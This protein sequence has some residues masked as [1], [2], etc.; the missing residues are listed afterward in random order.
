M[1]TPMH[2]MIRIPEH[3]MEVAYNEHNYPGSAFTDLSEGANC[4][5]FA[6]TLLEMNGIAIPPF[7]SSNLWEDTLYTKRVSAYQPLDL[8]LFH[9][10]PESFGAHVVVYLEHSRVI[11]L[12][13]NNG[14][15]KI[16]ALPDL[17]SQS[18]YAF[19]IGAKR[20]IQPAM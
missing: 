3:L 15:P 17:A 2:T 13:K 16:E 11:H 5:V 10:R 8:L 7:R 1:T 9:S 6:Y 4:Q 12:S 18:R 19:F 14:V 20:V